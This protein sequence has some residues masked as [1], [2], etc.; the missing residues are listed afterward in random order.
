MAS[1]CSS[2]GPSTGSPGSHDS[3]VIDKDMEDRSAQK[4]KAMEVVE[5]DNNGNIS[6]IVGNTSSSVLQSFSISLLPQV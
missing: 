6:E 4:Q 2:P 1:S 3:R 5:N